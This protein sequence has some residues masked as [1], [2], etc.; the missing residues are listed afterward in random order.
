MSR[1]TKGGIGKFS[2]SDLNQLLEKVERLLPV[3]ER[4]AANEDVA[5]SFMRQTAFVVFATQEG[6]SGLYNWV[7][8]KMDED[9]NLVGDIAESEDGEPIEGVRSGRVGNVAFGTEGYLLVNDDNFFGGACWCVEFR[10]PN[11]LFSYGLIPFRASSGTPTDTSTCDLIRLTPVVTQFT[12][13]SYTY[14]DDDEPNVDGVVYYAKYTN[15]S[16]VSA[17][18]QAGFDADIYYGPQDITLIDFSYQHPNLADVSPT[19][20]QMSYQP[21]ENGSFHLARKI[22]DTLYWMGETPRLSVTC[23]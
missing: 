16:R 23:G 20:P 13:G 3:M 19:Q 5:K 11:G 22:T 17:Q 1:F 14:N 15:C 12:E 6:A 2:F 18:G 7:E 21:L 10:N 9:M 8:A 4:A